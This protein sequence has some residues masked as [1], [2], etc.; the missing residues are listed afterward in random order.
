[1]SF[2]LHYQQQ[3]RGRRQIELPDFYQ[4]FISSEDANQL[5]EGLRHQTQTQPSDARVRN[6][7]ILQA[8]QRKEG[9]HV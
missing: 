2:L 3:G 1:M 4:G 6:A 7:A 9:C 8:K 5:S